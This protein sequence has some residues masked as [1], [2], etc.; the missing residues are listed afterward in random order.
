MADLHARTIMLLFRSAGSVTVSLGCSCLGTA[1]A[2]E[3]KAVLQTPLRFSKATFYLHVLASH[4]WFGL[5]ASLE[6]R[7]N[8]A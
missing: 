2:S 5:Y 3:S 1:H 4:G 6:P 8:D 7:S